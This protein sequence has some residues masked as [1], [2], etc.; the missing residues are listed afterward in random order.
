MSAYPIGPRVLVLGGSGLLGRSLRRHAPYDTVMLAPEQEDLPLEDR[1]KLAR[2]LR[3]EA[4]DRI[5]CLAA[6]TD[7]DGCESDPD[8]AFRVNGILPG[9]LALMADRLGLPI[10]FMSTDYVFDGESARPYREFDPARP[11][12]AYGRS[13]LY[14]ERAVRLANA[15]ASIVRSSGLYGAGG[16]NFVDAILGRARQGPVEV[17]TDE[18]NAPTFVEDLAPA[19]WKIAL[20]D[21]PGVWH[22]ANGGAVSRFECA[23]TIVSRAGF[24]PERVRPTTRARLGRPAPRPAYSVLNCQAAR[25][26]FGLLLPPWEDALSRYLEQAGGSAA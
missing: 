20:A 25:E 13:K 19:L 21:E 1:D 2:Y 5:L 14:G 9:R 23:R 16:P 24:D 7:V 8:L 10:L 22:L 17:V 3:D 12:S 18:V 4:V 26:V 15:R 11:L 6:W